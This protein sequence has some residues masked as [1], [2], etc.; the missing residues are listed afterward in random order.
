MVSK[1]TCKS[2]FESHW[3]PYSF[4]LVLHQ[5][6]ELCKLLYPDNPAGNLHDVVANMVDCIFSAC[7][8]IIIKACWWCGSF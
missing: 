8:V 3:V 5:S 4:G 2:E 6:K 1:Q 7:I